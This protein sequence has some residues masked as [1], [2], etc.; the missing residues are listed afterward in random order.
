MVEINLMAQYPRTKRNL[1]ERAEQKTKEDRAIAKKFGEEF[2]DGDRRHGYGGYNYHP[3][4]WTDVVQ[5]MIKHYRLTNKS[6]ILDVGCGKG[7][8]LHDFKKALPGIIIHGIDISKY[9]IENAMEDMKPFLSVG[10]AKDLS[11]FKDKEFDLV[12]SINTVHNLHL[13]GCKQA[14]R[15]IQRVGKNAFI[16]ND[17]WRNDEEQER[18]QIWNLTAE[19]YMHVDDWKKLFDEVGYRGDYYWF[20]P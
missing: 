16:V 11:M 5:D 6:K 19:T 4:F 17:A 14:L 10:N 13:E 8:M 12:V 15:E 3:R 2:F 18:M 9:A 20:F 1:D 7:F